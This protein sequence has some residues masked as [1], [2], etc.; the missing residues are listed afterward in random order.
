MMI[1]A[2]GSATGEA[3]QCGP[4]RADLV[5]R[6]ALEGQA[7]PLRVFSETSFCHTPATGDR[8]CSRHSFDRGTWI[9]VNHLR[10]HRSA[11]HRRDPHT[12]PM[13]SRPFLPRQTGEGV[14]T[15][16]DTVKNRHTVDSCRHEAFADHG[17]G[18]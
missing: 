8:R 7:G 13:L 18:F 4:M 3:R 11:C 5:K 16:V 12:L 1:V 15:S 17:M 14:S 9:A 2:V 6:R 10:V